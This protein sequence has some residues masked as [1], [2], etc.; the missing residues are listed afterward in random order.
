MT[1]SRAPYAKEMAAYARVI[2]RAWNDPEF[3]ER[4][5]TDPCT[6]FAAM[7]AHVPRVVV[8][9]VEN[10]D[11]LT[12]LML[13]A[14]PAEIEPS[15]GALEK[16]AGECFCRRPHANV[17]AR[18]WSDPGFKARLLADPNA[19]LAEADEPVPPGMTIRVV[20]NTE[21]LLHF[22][23]P[24]RPPRSELEDEVLQQAA[25]GTVSTNIV[26]TGPQPSR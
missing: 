13:P 9:A 5:L 18:A 25:S 12:H 22:I 2:A 15:R 26:N 3:K 10:T 11:K 23:L 8:K 16:A 14:R 6:A 4:L 21:K 19:A 17:V 24:A 1:E 20:E 7:G